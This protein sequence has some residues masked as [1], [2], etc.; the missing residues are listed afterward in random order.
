VNVLKCYIKDLERFP[1]VPALNS[2]AHA[3]ENGY[4]SREQ[5]IAANLRLAFWRAKRWSERYPRFDMMD[6][7]QEANLGLIKAADR[8]DWF[9]GTKFTTFAIC[10]IDTTIRNAIRAWSTLRGYAKV[11]DRDT[12]P[13]LASLDDDFGP[14]R[15]WESIFGT[16]RTEASAELL[17]AEEVAALAGWV[18]RL[19]LRE[20][21]VIRYRFGLDGVDQLTLAD[22]GMKLGVTRERVRQIEARALR[23]L[24]ELSHA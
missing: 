10:C 14:M 12:L 16:D 19:P 3:S 8:F 2:P 21:M 13:S 11:R 24:T 23:R 22:V 17:R 18:G 15:L 7:V 20:R 5:L 1:A 6:L 4:P 9:L